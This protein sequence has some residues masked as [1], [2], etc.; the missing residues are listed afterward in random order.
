M[1]HWSE[2]VCTRNQ[3]R[4]ALPVEDASGSCVVK[5]RVSEDL[6]ARISQRAETNSSVGVVSLTD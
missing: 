3:W 4:L 1:D 5:C 6:P 2:N